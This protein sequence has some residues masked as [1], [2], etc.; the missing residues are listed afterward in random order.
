MLAVIDTNV[1]VSAFLSPKGTPAKLLNA[2]LEGT[3]LPVYSA[4]IKIEYLDVLYRDKLAIG[5][6]VLGEFVGLL[7]ENG[8]LVSPLKFDSANLPDPDDAP[9]IATALAAGCCIITGN[10]KHFPP[11]FGAEILTPADAL[12]RL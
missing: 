6:D 2:F 7:E 8:I 1:W 5:H 4:E 3:L 10:T 11:K 9:F 12:A